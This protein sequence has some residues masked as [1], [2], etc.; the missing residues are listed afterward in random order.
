MANRK[1]TLIRL[2]KTEN[3]WRRYP[4]VVGKN[5]RVKPGFVQVGKTE[6]EYPEGRYQLRV[7]EGSK[8]KYVDAGNHAGSAQ[9]A[10]NRQTLILSAKHSAKEAGI[11]IEAIPERNSLVHFLDK[12]IEATHDRGSEV[13][14]ITYES[15]CREFLYILG[16]IYPDEILP[17]DILRHQQ[18][19][20]KRSMSDRTVRNRYN[21]VMSFLKFAG[22]DVKQLSPHKPKYEKTIPE[23]YNQEEL[24]VFFASLKTEQH[25]LIFDLLLK[26]GLREQEMM[27]LTWNNLDLRSCVL[28]VRSKL[29]VGFKIKDKEERDI[30]IPADLV[31]RLKSFR[32]KNPNTIWVAC[33]KNGK[34][35]TKLLYLTK[36]IARRA[37]LNCGHCQGCKRKECERW[38]LHKFRA[39]C[40]TTLLRSGMDL[41]TIMKFSGHSDLASVMRYLS[42]AED[43]T[44]KAHIN[45]MKW[46]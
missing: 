12:F 18:M 7:Y 17:A 24:A 46:R 38:F 36:G 25:H 4:A 39:T 3:G 6:K 28:H 16:K 1:A 34:P 31:A 5:G 44:V 2:C 45:Q 8:M 9:Q 10:H 26:T 21:S 35:N 14:A 22:L 32:A 19:L 37:G 15:H 40:I 11:K 30:P 33:T 43:A 29:E 23:S 13:A 42:P 27:Y 20:R 41:R